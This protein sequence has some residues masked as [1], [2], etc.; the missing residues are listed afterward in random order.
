MGWH[1]EYL[2]DLISL[3]R[4]RKNG[5]PLKGDDVSLEYEEYTCDVIFDFDT[6]RSVETDHRKK[7]RPYS[8]RAKGENTKSYSNLNKAAVLFL[9]HAEKLSPNKK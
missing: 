1:V 4:I 6:G 2:E 5:V 3:H 9:A 7:T 8:V